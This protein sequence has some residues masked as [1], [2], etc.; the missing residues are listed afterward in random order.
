MSKAPY[1][2]WWRVYQLNCAY[3]EEDPECTLGPVACVDH[4]V[5]RG[6]RRPLAAPGGA[7]ST[8]QDTRFL[9]APTVGTH[10]YSV[11]AG[12]IRPLTDTL[13]NAV[14]PLIHRDLKYNLPSAAG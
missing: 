12:E 4:S 9:L 6:S 3:W 2:G 11:F 8:G 7:D 10:R 14:Y 1:R 5:T 13:G